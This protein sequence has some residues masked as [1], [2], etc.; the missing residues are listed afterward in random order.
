MIG[1]A[2]ADWRGHDGEVPQRD[3]TGAKVLPDGT[4]VAPMQGRIVKGP[5]YLTV[6]DGPT[7]KALATAPYDPPRY[8]GGNPTTAQL[9]ESWGDGYANRSDRFLAGVAYLDGHLP[10]MVFGRGYYA[11]TAIAAWDWRDGKLTQRWLFDSSCLLYT[12]PSPR[13]S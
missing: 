4:K 12:S 1:D 7:G 5:E 11:R 2:K 9:T 8:P 13:D 3:R 10:S 6:F